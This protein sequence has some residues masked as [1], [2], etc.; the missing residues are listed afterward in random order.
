MTAGPGTGRLVTDGLRPVLLEEFDGPHLDR[1]RWVPYHLPQWSSRALAAARYT[2]ADGA[3]VLRV[4]PDQPPWCPWLDGTT[5]VSSLQTGVRSGPVGSTDGQHRFSPDAVVREEQPTQMLFTPSS[6][7]VT[8]RAAFPAD[9]DAMA[10]VWLV[11][12][13]DEPHRSGEICVA[14][15]FGRDVAPGRALVGT[16]V[17]PFGDSDLVDD[18]AQVPVE[19]DVTEPHEWAVRWTAGRVETFVDGRPLRVVD[20]APDYPVQLMVGLY[21]FAPP[22]RCGARTPT[23]R[24]EHVHAYALPD[25]PG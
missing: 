21:D 13:E 10:A 6:G 18:V 1:T 12:V 2:L 22:E 4:D 7:V 15:V 20:Q 23:F 17:H 24:V 5:R 25:G 16:G 11:G 14:E 8:V 19:V 9:P 3:L